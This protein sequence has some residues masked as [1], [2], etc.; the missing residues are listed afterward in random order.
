MMMDPPAKRLRIL[1]SVEV[2]ET[3]PDY[4]AAKQKQQHK[5]K[6]RFESIFAKY[7]GMHESMSDEIDLKTGQV[8][9]DRG[10]VR[11]V[12]RQMLQKATLLD[13]FLEPALGQEETP[14]GEE[15]H[16]QSEDELAPTQLPSKKRKRV[17]AQDHEK[18]AHSSEQNGADLLTSPSHAVS[19]V[20][21]Q[22]NALQI[23]NTPNPAANLLQH[24]QFPQTPLGQQA[25]AAFL[26]N[27]NQTIAQAVQQA[28]A[29]ILSSVLRTTPNVQAA[30]TPVFPGLNSHVSAIDSVRPATDP[31][32]YFPPVSVTKEAQQVD[33]QRSTPPVLHKAFPVTIDRP[34]ASSPLVHRRSSPKV[35][36]QKRRNTSNIQ[37]NARVLETSAERPQSSHSLP[38]LCSNVES[39]IATEPP[40]TDLSKPKTKRAR[41]ARKKYHF[42]EEDNI[43]I[44]KSKILHN[45]SFKEIRASKEKWSNWPYSAFYKHWSSYLKDKQL[46]LQDISRAE[47]ILQPSSPTPPDHEEHFFS[48]IEIPETSSASHR[49]PTPD[50]LEQDDDCVERAVIPS[51]SHFDDDELEL[52]SLAGADVGDLHSSQTQYDVDDTYPTPDEPIPSIEGTEFRNED[53]LQLEMLKAESLTPEPTLPKLLPSTIPETQESVVVVSSPSQKRQKIERPRPNPV[54]TQRAASDSSDDLDLIGTN[55]EPATPHNIPIKREPETPQASLFLCSSPAFKTSRPVPQSSGLTKSTGKLDRRVYLKEVKQSWTKGKG[56]MSSA[57]RRRRRSSALPVNV[58]RARVDIEVGDSEDELAL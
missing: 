36:I 11:R 9:V 31:K 42:T 23:P 29:P 45:K 26:A 20:L 46:H 52:L 37:H 5:L 13:N 33:Y 14:E 39:Y 44:S 32:W 4:I 22:N 54:S 49:L 56:R 10:H 48:S 7:E 3:N 21:A 19:T 27:L 55:D 47:P 34:D 1:Q 38:T 43:Y 12:Q 58:K 51:S 50:S 35:Y 28:V 17:D 53:E 25:Q 40:V 15:E 8:V 57:K 41:S 18:A 30:P 2:D 6:G 24:I 16:V